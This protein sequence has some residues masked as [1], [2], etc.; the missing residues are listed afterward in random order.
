MQVV[1]DSRAW[2]QCHS[3]RDERAARPQEEEV[4][5][6]VEGEFGMGAV[7]EGTA[8]Q[9]GNQMP[10]RPHAQYSVSHQRNNDSKVWTACKY[11]FVNNRHMYLMEL[12]I[13]QDLAV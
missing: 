11:S 1:K 3:R 12:S 7:G 4:E 2:V 5:V 6:G 10:P 8:P 13:L 9:P